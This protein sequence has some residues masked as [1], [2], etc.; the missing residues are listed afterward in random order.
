MVNSSLKAQN[1][2]QWG[3]GMF[4]SDYTQQDISLANKMWSSVTTEEEQKELI[5]KS[6]T[7]ISIT[8]P[9]NKATWVENGK[10][11]NQYYF[12]K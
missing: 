1:H 8:A 4:S 6:L 11:N 7:G 10:I 3:Y 12:I 2:S 9:S 5:G